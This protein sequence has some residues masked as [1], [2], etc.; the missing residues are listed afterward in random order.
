[1][2]VTCSPIIQGIKDKIVNDEEY[3]PRPDEA[4]RVFHPH[5]N[6]RF[7]ELLEGKVDRREALMHLKVLYY[8]D[9]MRK[10]DEKKR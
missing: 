7:N 5:F 4:F 3:D 6:F 9:F 10:R 2:G 1:M 8:D